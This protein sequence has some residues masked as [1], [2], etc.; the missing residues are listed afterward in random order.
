MTFSIS[1]LEALIPRKKFYAG[2]WW[3]PKIDLYLLI[4]P[5]SKDPKQMVKR[6][7]QSCR[8]E[9]VDI[10]TKYLPMR[11]HDGQVQPYAF[12]NRRGRK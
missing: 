3:F 5:Q 9:G 1:N 8:K 10:P 7:M 2:A 6:I 12:T 4:N 11:T